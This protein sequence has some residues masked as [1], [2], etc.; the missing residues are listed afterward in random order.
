MS[1]TAAGDNLARATALASF[2]I[3]DFNVKYIKLLI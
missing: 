2:F 1:L 3:L